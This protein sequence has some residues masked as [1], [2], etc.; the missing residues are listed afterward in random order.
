MHFL[1]DTVRKIM[2]GWS[3][4]C[5]CSH[6]KKIYYYLLNDNI[7]NKIHIPEEYA[8]QLPADIENYTTIIICRNPYK[9]ITS[10]LM[11]KYLI[12]GE[13]RHLWEG[14]VV[15]FNTFVDELIKNDW[16]LIEKHHFTP[17]T[18]ETF[19]EGKLLK[20][21]CIK[22]YD[23]EN[24]D[25]D[26]IEKLYEKKIPV[27][28]LNYR[29]E[30]HSIRQYTD[31]TFEKYVY[32]MNIDEYSKYKINIKYFYNE[33]LKNKIHNFYINDFN[34]FHKFGFDYEVV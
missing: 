31:E 7:D 29:G 13:F 6:V 24:I 5:G 18:S 12:D 15:T 2:F 9:R 34:F 21:K 11:D 16:R 1:V 25:Y 20:S 8:S 33:E 22:F 27:E 10:G 26:F 14:D 32:D 3:A 4:K 19:N 30:R 23:I 28:L 17:Q